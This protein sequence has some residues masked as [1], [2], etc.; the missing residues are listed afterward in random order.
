MHTPSPPRAVRSQAPPSGS[1]RASSSRCRRARQH[2]H[3]HVQS[4]S[5][6][7]CALTSHLAAPLFPSVMRG[8]QKELPVPHES[9]SK[10]KHRVLFPC[11]R[12]SGPGPRSSRR[13]GLWASEL[14]KSAEKQAQP[15]RAAPPG[16]GG[17]GP[18]ARP[19]HGWKGRARPLCT[20]TP[21]P[22]T[23]PGGKSFGKSSRYPDF[24]PLRNHLWLT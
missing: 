5:D 2:K 19:R 24:S 15:G 7:I 6:Q 1:S 11:E 9:N 14:W 12:S 20:P 13:G 22:G 4:V 18:S 16:R 23:D 17:L 8:T 10:A 3:R 21:E